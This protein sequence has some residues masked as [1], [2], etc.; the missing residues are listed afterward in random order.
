[1]DTFKN[2]LPLIV[3]TLLGLIFF[4]RPVVPSSAR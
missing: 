3:R 2:K 4:P 1:M